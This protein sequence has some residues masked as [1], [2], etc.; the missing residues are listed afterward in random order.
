MPASRAR[1]R[2]PPSS[3]PPVRGAVAGAGRDY[4]VSRPPARLLPIGRITGVYGVKGWL[5]VRSAT[6]PRERILRYAP[7]QVR[8]HGDWV[9][10]TLEGGRVQ[11]ESILVKLVGVDDRETAQGWV[12]ADIAICRAQLP[13]LDEDEF[14]WCDLVGL[15]VR[16]AR[17]RTLGTVAQLMET[18]ANDVLVV[19]GAR[20]HLIPFVMKQ[21]VREVDVH[22][23]RIIVDWDPNF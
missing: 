10:R 2:R 13:E 18:G 14:Y 15:E 21:V 22:R 6:E 9:A 3:G 4:A 11:G 1:T 12:G 17:G 5:R 16:D 19:R 20:E 8:L 23:G 7:W